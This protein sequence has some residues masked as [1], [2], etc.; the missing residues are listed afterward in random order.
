MKNNTVGHPLL[1]LKLSLQ[2]PMSWKFLEDPGAFYLVTKHSGRSQA[3]GGSLRRER[4][5][6]MTAEWRDRVSTQET[7]LH[8]HSWSQ[9]LVPTLPS[10]QHQCLLLARHKTWPLWHMR[11]DTQSLTGHSNEAFPWSLGFLKVSRTIL[12]ERQDSDGRN[13]DLRSQL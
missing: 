11:L 6:Y 7:L 4:H 13:Q 10:I 12:N 3:L 1:Y 5:T 2:L 9:P 8:T